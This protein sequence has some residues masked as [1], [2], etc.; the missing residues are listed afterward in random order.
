MTFDV[1]TVIAKV[2]CKTPDESILMLVGDTVAVEIVGR[3]LGHPPPGQK[4]S[5][6]EATLELALL[7]LVARTSVNTAYCEP[8][9]KTGG[10]APGSAAVQ[11]LPSPELSGN[12]VGSAAT[13]P[14]GWVV[15]VLS[16]T[17]T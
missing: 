12:C 5:V 8:A 9:P 14:S 2:D 16:V 13:V 7:S 1:D 4:R 10:V 11:V 6:V 17:Y 15:S 3:P